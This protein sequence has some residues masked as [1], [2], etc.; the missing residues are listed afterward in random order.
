[1]KR[2]EI[3]LWLL[4][5]IG[6]VF[7]L[8]HWSGGHPIVT[9]SMLGLS[10]LYMVFSFMLLNN[11]RLQTI[12]VKKGYAGVSAG[13]II[14]SIITG[15]C[16]AM[17]VV[18]IMFAINNWPGS[19]PMLFVAILNSIP[20]FVGIFIWYMNDKNAFTIRAV[21]RLAFLGAVC[22]VLYYTEMYNTDR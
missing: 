15:W 21:K 20:V 7:V 16:L 13:R 4:F 11:V 1:M 22:M 8:N 2:V 6:L 9:L 5:L 3:V 17:Q 18:G 14:A 12:F 19:G 10:A